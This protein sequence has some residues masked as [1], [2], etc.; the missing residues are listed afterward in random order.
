MVLPLVF[1]CL[2]GNSDRHHSNWGVIPYIKNVDD[3]NI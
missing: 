1:D 2:I 3:E